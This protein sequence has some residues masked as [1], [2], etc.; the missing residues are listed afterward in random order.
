MSKV[1]YQIVLSRSERELMTLDA[2]AASTGLHPAL[3]ECFVD[4][5]LLEPVERTGAQMLFNVDC[6][7]RLHSIVRL[8][9][10][11]GANLPGIAMILDLRDRLAAL[12]RENDWLRSQNDRSK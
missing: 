2:L 9:R 10:D 5:G 3:I 4:F 8:R 11:V 6:I 1:R 12:Q 7:T